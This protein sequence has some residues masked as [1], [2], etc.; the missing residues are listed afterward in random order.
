MPGAVC[1]PTLAQWPA[2]VCEALAAS[3]S[4]LKKVEPVMPAAQC[5]TFGDFVLERAQQRLRHRDG[6]PI[7]L[8]PRLFNTLLLFVERAG[9]LVD[10]DTLMRE[11]WP[12]LVVEENNL[13]QVISGLRRALGDETQDSRYIQTVPRRGFRFVAAVSPCN[14]ADIAPAALPATAES[15]HGSRS[16]AARRRSV[17]AGFALAASA[18]GAALWWRHRTA[19]A[20]GAPIGLAVLP[21]KPLVI[22]GR[23][24]LLEIGMADSLIA[25]LSRLP[26]LTVRSVGSVRRF[27]GPDQDPLLAA[28]EL[29]VQWVVDG[30]LQRRANQLRVTARLLSA[31]EGTAA[32]SGSFD[33]RAEGVFEMQDAIAE[34]V[35]G[36]LVARLSGRGLFPASMKDPAGTRNADAYQLYLAARQHAQGIRAAGLKKSA[37]LYNKALAIDESYALAYAGLAET[38]RRMIFGAELVPS[39]VF[40]PARIA[41]GRALTLQPALA[42]AHAGL[43]WV[44]FWFDFDWPAAERGFRQAIDFSPNVAEAWL[45]LGLLL[46]STGRGDEG[47]RHVRTARELD[48]MSQI[49]NTLEAVLLFDLGAQQEAELRLQRA[50]EIDPD[51][52]VAHLTRAG[53]LWAAQQREQAVEAARRSEV[54]ADGSTQPAAVLATFLARL[55]RRDEAAQVLERLVALEKSRYV[56]PTSVAAVHAALGDLGAALDALERAWHVRDTRLVYLR[57]DGRW[58][59]LRAEPRFAALLRRMKLDS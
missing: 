15:P 24:E 30:S 23:D 41:I 39:D 18:A 21:F 31:P 40:E 51:F 12:G 25:R 3:E 55:G 29:R 59:G 44:R 53:F 54:L 16:A 27:A 2:Q 26:G 42:E 33:E 28:R 56:P 6:R 22:E 8:T 58:A 57:V 52:W 36:V 46:S 11:L 20:P 19:P 49:L 47:L 45:G 14:E 34:R 1:I 48:P 43:A 50:L 5:Y 10:K 7:T 38:Y 9:E 13:S 4:S 17:L 35:A 37:E 32:W